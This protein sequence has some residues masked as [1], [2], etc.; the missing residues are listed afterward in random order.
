MRKVIF[1]SACIIAGML[2]VLV[3]LFVG[4]FPNAIS[5]LSLLGKCIIW[6]GVLMAVFGV[7]FCLCN[8]EE[9]NGE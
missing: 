2:L 5:S 4:A 8:L 7:I 3:L 6:L 9:T 1:G